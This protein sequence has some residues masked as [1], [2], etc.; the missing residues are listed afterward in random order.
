[1]SA[2]DYGGEETWVNDA[3]GTSSRDSFVA[4][5]WAAGRGRVT[6]RIGGLAWHG[7]VMPLATVAALHMMRGEAN[8]HGGP[9]EAI[10]IVAAELPGQGSAVDR[11]AL[12]VVLLNE[13][14]A[15]RHPGGWSF[16][17]PAA[18]GVEDTTTIGIPLAASA[19][20][21]SAWVVGRDDLYKLQE[22]RLVA[23]NRPDM[24][25]SAVVAL[26]QTDGGVL[27]LRF[28]AM[29]TSLVPVTTTAVDAR[30]RSAALWSALA[31]D[32]LGETYLARTTDDQQRLEVITLNQAGGE[33][34]RF[35]SVIS[36]PVARI[37]LQPAGEALYAVLYQDDSYRLVEMTDEGLTLL[38]ESR[39]PIAGPHATADGTV[40]VSIDGKLSKITGSAVEATTETAAVTCLRRWKSLHY[41]CV[42]AELHGLGADGLEE[43]WFTV[44]GIAPP[45][46]GLGSQSSAQRCDGQWQ[47]FLTDLVKA[48][49]RPGTAVDAPGPIGGEPAAPDGQAGTG[50]DASVVPVGPSAGPPA[51]D[52]ASGCG[53]AVPGRPTAPV[54]GA[55]LWVVAVAAVARCRRDRPK[56]QAAS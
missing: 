6:A 4:K 51:A 16:V 25:A 36:S 26:A 53:C 38:A 24:S 28:D 48:G 12:Q 39:L 47:L 37:S 23:Q 49:L 9:P 45:V 54:G 50:A 30:F 33:L 34:R 42:G 35:E 46:A 13:G 10:A 15:V 44:D 40:W 19:D 56:R 2:G 41:A 43:R 29:G 31:V 17:C 5:R 52:E 22:R 27:G 21:Y 20:A 8:A 18:W 11:T 32:E 55:I 3:G 14:L 7:L 1:M